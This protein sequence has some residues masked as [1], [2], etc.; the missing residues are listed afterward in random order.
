MAGV[1]NPYPN[2]ARIGPV[3]GKASDDFLFQFKLSADRNGVAALAPNSIQRNFAA[4]YAPVPIAFGDQSPEEWKANNAGE[5]TLEF[6]IVGNGQMSVL[7]TVRKLRK[8][9][10]KDSRSGEPPDLVFAIGSQHWIVRIHRLSEKP[11]LW[12]SDTDESRTR[13]TVTLHTKS[14]DD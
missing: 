11:V 8:L 7:N 5:I 9:M 10:R 12:N 13:V 1:I 3:K 14:W 4:V 6:E 2:G